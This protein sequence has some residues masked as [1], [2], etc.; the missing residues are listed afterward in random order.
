MEA[1]DTCH[2]LNAARV[3]LNRNYLLEWGRRDPSTSLQEERAGPMPL[4][5]FETRAVDA[6]VRRV[7]PRAYLTVHSGDRAILIPWDSGRAVGGFIQ[8]VARRIALKHCRDCKVGSAS[9]LFGYRAYGSGVDHMLGVREVPFACTL[10]IFG[11]EDKICDRMFNPATMSDFNDVMRNWSGVLETVAREVRGEDRNGGRIGWF[12]SGLLGRGYRVQF[13][14]DGVP[15]ERSAE[16]ED[17][18]H[19]EGSFLLGVFIV[20]AFSL[21][22][23]VAKRGMRRFG[24][25]VLSG[26]ATEG[27]S[28]SGR[29]MTA[30]VDTSAIR[31]RTV[32]VTV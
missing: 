6:V 27:T 10:E 22:A 20:S 7:Q 31:K 3:D 12:E 11:R 19:A 29:R 15:L 4:S 16:V 21:M 2:R 30:K 13:V 8:D 24:R 5:E 25:K 17:I 1:G 26:S 9:A 32:V 14:P 18:E 28:H 23:L